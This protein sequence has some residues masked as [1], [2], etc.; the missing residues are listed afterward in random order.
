MRLAA[1]PLWFHGGSGRRLAAGPSSAG[2]AQPVTLCQGRRVMMGS[3]SDETALLEI[4]AEDPRAVELV[5]AIRGGDIEA[6]RRHLAADPGLALA[7]IVDRKGG[8]RTLLHVVTDW[9]GPRLDALRRVVLAA[10]RGGGPG[11][12]ARSL[13]RLGTPW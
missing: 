9:P 13:W 2:D 6:V 10:E 7:G 3:M 12:V 4:P 8:F 1:R 11:G 5:L